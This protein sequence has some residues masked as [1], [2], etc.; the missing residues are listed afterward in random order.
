MQ[1]KNKGKPRYDRRRKVTMAKKVARDDLTEKRNPRVSL[2][3][4]VESYRGV[5]PRMVGSSLSFS[6]FADEMDVNAFEKII[7]CQLAPFH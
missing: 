1:G 3:T 5:I 7:Q 2:D 6:G 4:L